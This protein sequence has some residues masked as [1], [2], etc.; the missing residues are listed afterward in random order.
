[1]RYCCVTADLPKWVPFFSGLFRWW[2]ASFSWRP[3]VFSLPP[4]RP[5]FTSPYDRPMTSLL[6]F[7]LFNVVSAQLTL[8]SPPWTPP[9]AS[10]GSFPSNATGIPNPEWTN[11]LG[12][13][14]YFYDE[15]RSGNLS[16]N[17]RV[18]WR[19]TSCMQDGQDAGLDLTGGYYDAGG[20]A[21]GCVLD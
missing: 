2:H 21:V 19:N 15:Q 11:L 6:L 4:R 18:S 10:N 9:D 20:T 13:L 12:S 17:N 7:L 14:I 5:S 1:M 16:E 8:P 3:F